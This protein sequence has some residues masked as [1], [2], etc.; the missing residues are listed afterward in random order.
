MDQK[1]LQEL[2]EDLH[3]ERQELLS[4]MDMPG[5]VKMTDDLDNADQGELSIQYSTLES[6]SL[7]RHDLQDRLNAIDAALQRIDAGTYGIC[8]NCGKEISLDRLKA[9]P[10]AELCLDCFEKMS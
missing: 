1:S 6:A 9:Q 3:R 10:E 2:K 7:V 5:Q 4:L 8:A